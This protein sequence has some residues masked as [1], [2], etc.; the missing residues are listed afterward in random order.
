MEAEST[1]KEA[2]ET[3]AGIRKRFARSRCT[4]KKSFLRS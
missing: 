3:E 1:V 2:A 4:I